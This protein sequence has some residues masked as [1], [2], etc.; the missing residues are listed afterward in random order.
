MKQMAVL[1]ILYLVP[2]VGSADKATE[3]AAMT[4]RNINGGGFLSGLEVQMRF[5]EM[6][7]RIVTNCSDVYSPSDAADKLVVAWNELRK[8]GLDKQ[9][10]LVDFTD[11]AE[12]L[13]RTHRG[14]W[15]SNQAGNC[16]GLWAPYVALR[17]RG[18]PPETAKQGVHEMTARK[19]SGGR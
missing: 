11:N 17:I 18:Y 13:A 19:V 6:L 12:R 3:E 15:W 1:A 14:T 8:A 7:P 9:E 16:I 10:S 4:L 2:T 5:R